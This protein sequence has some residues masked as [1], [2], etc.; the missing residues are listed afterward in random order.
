MDRP[1]DRNATQ[2]FEVFPDG[3]TL[4]GLEEHIRVLRERGA[5]D[6]AHPVV[7]INDNGEIAGMVCVVE[8]W[9]PL[10]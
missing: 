9:Q 3:A 6:D 4:A 10:G 8:R 5:P 1:E 7:R 2:V